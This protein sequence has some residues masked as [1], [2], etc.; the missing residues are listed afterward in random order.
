MLEAALRDRPKRISSIDPVKFLGAN[1]PVRTDANGKSRLVGDDEENPNG[2]RF[3]SF[4]KQLAEALGVTKDFVMDRIINGLLHDE[5]MLKELCEHLTG[6]SEHYKQ[7][8]SLIKDEPLN[9]PVTI[10]IGTTNLIN[11]RVLPNVLEAAR[12]RFH[13]SYPDVQLHF[14]QTIL[15]SDE[16]LSSSQPMTGVD[17]IVACC[18]KSRVAK[19]PATQLAV[20][21]PL[22]CCLLRARTETTLPRE[23]RALRSWDE[24]RGTDMVVV[25]SRKK[26]FDVPWDEIE[27]LG[28]IE[29]VPTLLEAHARV[30]ASD[31]WTLSYRELMDEGDEQRLEILELPPDPQRQS[32]ML[33]ALFP[34]SKVAAN[35]TA[36]TDGTGPEKRSA[37]LLLKECLDEEF[38]QRQAIQRESEELTAWLS[39]FAY[40]YHVSDYAVD[41]ETGSQRMWISG[42]AHLEC[43][44]NGNLTGSLCLGIPIADPLQMRVFG[45]PLRYQDGN[46]WHL[47]WRTVDQ[48]AQSGT[49]NL[50]VSRIALKE[51]NVLVGSWMGRSSWLPD[52]IRPSGGPFVLH[53]QPNLTALELRHIIEEH[54]DL[55]IPNIREVASDVVPLTHEPKTVSPQVA[56][57]RKPRLGK[58]R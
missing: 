14:I 38:L 3:H 31:D 4:C 36:D 23:A 39:R 42:R 44:S 7:A 51:G 27:S 47:Q 22:R 50:V 12:Q 25:A 37:L 18:L 29:E 43:T 56:V 57:P 45:R 9:R 41:S 1:L 54:R 19:I 46:V 53:T 30:A 52:E 35:G 32:P 20:S 11:M 6:A 13:A 8:M 49:T 28:A 33:V 24:L 48:V 2:A 40:S 21:M 55:C 5:S 26:H 15:N 58:P 17:A 16:L 34:K 10:R